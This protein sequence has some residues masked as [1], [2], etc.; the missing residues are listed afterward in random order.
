M[1]LLGVDVVIGEDEAVVEGTEV[2]GDIVAI[3]CGA[4]HWVMGTACCYQGGAGEDT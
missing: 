2:A 1:N 3:W 4:H